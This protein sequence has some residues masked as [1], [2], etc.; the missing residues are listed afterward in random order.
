V[1]SACVGAVHA[2]CA[3]VPRA[4]HGDD[5]YRLVCAKC[6]PPKG[7][8]TRHPIGWC[9]VVA[10]SRTHRERESACVRAHACVCAPWDAPWT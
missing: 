9:V 4:F 5:F 2:A 8:Y 7:S 1:R 6:E 10:T 3:G